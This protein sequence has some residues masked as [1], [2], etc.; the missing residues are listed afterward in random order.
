MQDAAVVGVQ[1]QP[2]LPVQAFL[3]VRA[4]QVEASGSEVLLFRKLYFK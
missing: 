4:P 2:E 3:L 1:P